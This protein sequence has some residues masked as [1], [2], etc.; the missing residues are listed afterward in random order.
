MDGDFLITCNGPSLSLAPYLYYLTLAS[1]QSYEAGTTVSILYTGELTPRE[2]ELC[3][4]G[5]RSSRSCARMEALWKQGSYTPLFSQ[6]SEQ[7]PTCSKCSINICWE[8]MGKMASPGSVNSM[9]VSF[10]WCLCRDEGN[11]AAH[12]HRREGLW[13]MMRGGASKRQVME[14][15]GNPTVQGSSVSPPQCLPWSHL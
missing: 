9:W 12:L 4:Q 10:S 1:P 14:I 15:W 7:C 13:G 5:Q 8:Q 11:K 3:N 2:V 6:L